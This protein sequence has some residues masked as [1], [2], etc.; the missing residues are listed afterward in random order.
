MAWQGGE[1]LVPD[2]LVLCMLRAVRSYI[3]P[4]VE[5]QNTQV[6]ADE[7]THGKYKEHIR[8]KRTTGMQKT[9]NSLHTDYDLL[10]VLYVL[11]Y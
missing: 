9:L 6:V 5:G 3:W 8:Y 11:F 2:I 7:Y 1:Y 4:G 10:Y